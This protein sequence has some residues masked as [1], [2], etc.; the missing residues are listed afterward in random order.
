MWELKKLE[1]KKILENAADSQI[2]GAPF[3][4]A[5]LYDVSI[6]QIH[7]HHANRTLESALHALVTVPVGDSN[8]V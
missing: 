3:V 8:G 5:P 4:S 7:G 6:T 2:S 1:T